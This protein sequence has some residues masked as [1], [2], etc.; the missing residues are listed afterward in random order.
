MDYEKRLRLA[1]SFITGLFFAG[2]LGYVFLEGWP[3]LDAF[4]MAVITLTTV[5]FG[6]IR[7]LSEN[8]RLFTVFLIVAGVG[9][10]AYSVSVF[11]ELIIEG[12]I[13]EILGKK[14]ME[15]ELNKL[16]DHYIVCGYGRI[17]RTVCQ[18]FKENKVPF[19]VI[20]S[21]PEIVAK[22][23]E[24]GVLLIQ[25]DATEEDILLK[26]GMERAKAL[27]AALALD[28]QNVFITLTARSLNPNLFITARAEE[29]LSEKK[30]LRAGANKVVLPYLIG[31]N[32]LAYSVLKPALVDF[33]EIA[34]QR[35]RIDLIM[36]EI[37]VKTGSRLKGK[38]LK[39][40]RISP[41]LGIIVVAIKKEDEMVFNPSADTE[42]EQGD[43]LIV[44]GNE[45]QLKG[46]EEWAQS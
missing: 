13:R 7:P 43:K 16:K 15:K 27:V 26:A 30:L 37:T 5:G 40:S 25:G 32:R 9:S 46:M 10:I 45:K 17:G 18:E 36:E 22:A 2:T 21:N 8:G 19:V 20:E 35:E 39:E 1:L 24:D 44:L 38:S 34:T 33:L 31:G 42:I 6:E 3:W 29:P 23:E 14:R 11:T 41:D 4:Y 28:S 12:R